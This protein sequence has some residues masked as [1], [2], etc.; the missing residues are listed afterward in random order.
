M[1]FKPR[2]EWEREAFDIERPRFDLG[3]RVRVTL[4]SGTLVGRVTDIYLRTVDW[5]FWRYQIDDRPEW[6]EVSDIERLH[7]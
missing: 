5:P 6:Y 3:E 1:K 4:P 7:K 2:N